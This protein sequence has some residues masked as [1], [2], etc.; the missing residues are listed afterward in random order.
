MPTLRPGRTARLA[1]ANHRT[2]GASRPAKG[3]SPGS[4]DEQEKK[5]QHLN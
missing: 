2:T 4:A 5:H 1:P 3:S